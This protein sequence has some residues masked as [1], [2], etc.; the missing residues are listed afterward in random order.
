MRADVFTPDGA[1]YVQIE[2]M[3]ALLSRQ[4]DELMALQQRQEKLKQDIWEQNVRAKFA[5]RPEEAPR[6]RI[7][8]VTEAWELQLK[9]SS[10]L[11]QANRDDLAA[12]NH[13]YMEEGW[14]YWK[15]PAPHLLPAPPLMG[16][17]GSSADQYPMF[18]EP[19]SNKLPENRLG[20]SGATTLMVRN[21]PV[22]YTQE[23]LLKEWPNKGTYDF[24][25]LPI[26]IKKK[27]NAS[28]AFINF[29]TPEAAQAFAEKWHHERLVFFSSR[30]PLDISLADLQGLE[31]NLLQCMNNKTSRIRN[32]RFQ[33][34]VFKG[35][36]RISVDEVLQE[37]R[38]KMA[39]TQ[40]EPG[41]SVEAFAPG[42][43][44][45]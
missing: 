15:S 40:E 4:M 16:C 30:K 1:D 45:C 24:L 38:R 42:M 2:D 28:F 23:M 18:A 7:G 19:K 33:P 26:C 31:K 21:I 20:N 39:F 36:E 29:L 27:C 44:Q 11:F 17:R 25:Y 8:K 3:T 37:M 41:M 43:W 14:Q 10:E 34:A 6:T 35:D 32:V 13:Q 22:R 12:M 5:E 9:T